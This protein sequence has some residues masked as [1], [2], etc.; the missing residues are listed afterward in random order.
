M[1]EH[2][3]AHFSNPQ[4]EELSRSQNRYS[5]TWAMPEPLGRYDCESRL[6][7]YCFG[8]QSLHQAKN[9]PIIFIGHSLGGIVIKTV[10]S[11][12]PSQVHNSKKKFPT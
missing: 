5:S 9:R 2:F 1:H 4:Q 12:R 3:F 8:L 11:S 6:H 7:K 10:S